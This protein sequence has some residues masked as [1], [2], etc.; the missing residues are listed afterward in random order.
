[1]PAF[2][3]LAFRREQV[4]DP[5]RLSSREIEQSSRKSNSSGPGKTSIIREKTNESNGLVCYGPYDGRFLGARV[6]QPEGAG[7][8]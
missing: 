2:I 1:M 6:A 3:F 4:W 5:C 8:A 7:K